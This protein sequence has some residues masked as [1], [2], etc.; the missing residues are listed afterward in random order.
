MIARIGLRSSEP[1]PRSGG[2][3]RRKRFRYGSTLVSSMKPITVRSAGLYGSAELLDPAQ[4]DA[5][6]IRSEGRR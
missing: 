2:M 6:M 3:K 1:R 4:E 5:T